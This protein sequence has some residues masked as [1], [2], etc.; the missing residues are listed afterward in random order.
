MKK[1]F[2]LLLVIVIYQAAFATIYYVGPNQPY[3]TIQEAINVAADGDTIIVDPG[4]YDQINYLSKDLTIASRYFE[5]NDPTYIDN[6]IISGTNPFDGA[7]TINSGGRTELN[8]FTVTGGLHGIFAHQLYATDPTFVLN[9]QI[10]NN[11]ECGIDYVNGTPTSLYVDNCRISDNYTGISVIGFCSAT[12]ENTKIHNCKI[13][14]YYEGTEPMSAP[15]SCITSEINNCEIYHIFNEGIVFMWTEININYSL[16]M[17]NNIAFEEIW[18]GPQYPASYV[19]LMHT[20]ITE[21]SIVFSNFHNNNQTNILNVKNSIIWNN[22]N[23]QIPIQSDISYSD[24][25]NGY[26]GTGNI[27]EDPLFENP[28]YYEFTLKWTETEKSPCID[29]GDPDPQYNDPDGTRADMGAYYYPHE[30]KIYRFPDENTNRGWKW[31]CFDILDRTLEPYNIAEYMLFP[32]REDEFL[33]Y[34]LFKDHGSITPVE[35]IEY[36]GEELWLNGDHPFTSPYGYKF[37]TWNACILEIP[38]F[39][40]EA[41]TTFFVAGNDEQNWI[42]YFLEE[43]QHVY[44]A[45][46]GY[47]DNIYK[48]QA[49]HWSVE[50]HN[51]WPDVPYTLSPGDMVIVWCND[52][53][54]N[55]SW[56]NDTP[57]EAFNIEEPQNFTYSEEANYIP[58]YMQLNPEDLPTEIGALIDGECQ[59]ATV[60]QDTLAQICAYIL[61]NQG[62][63]EFEFYYD[64]RAQNKV[65]KEYYVYN[66][67]TSRTEKGFIKIEN[68]RTSYYVSFKD[69]PE[70]TPAPIKLEA[71]NY[72]NPFN[73]VTTIAYSLHE[74]SQIS[75]S[76]YNIK[77]QKVNTLVTG[78]QPAG[79]YN[80]SWDGKD[81]KGKPVSSGVYYY[82]LVTD[83][84][85]INKK[86][87]LLK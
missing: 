21:N 47:L 57:R 56:V 45:F 20:T 83:N 29:T 27:D 5:T 81:E 52:D 3:E 49:Q 8:G 74:D 34:A 25:Q 44:D 41:T 12:I 75:I 38:G 15:E 50:E 60:V 10:L 2:F 33:D 46:Y 18:W 35:R 14:I 62:S 69:E 78:T 1:I 7:V 73:P 30:V 85:T 51:G 32:I 55:F 76:I 22:T 31:L 63:L 6:T 13:G 72:P 87:L 16:L 77:G 82:K 71:S 84:K 17:N 86:M 67:E 40:C 4:E 43:T 26:A 53:I 24:I 48:I 42:G 54:P 70:S 79:D 66:P 61:G 36:L 64:G 11:S 19:N 37:R 39:R 28:N 65:I 58:I 23:M 59:G 80:V 68:N 9:C